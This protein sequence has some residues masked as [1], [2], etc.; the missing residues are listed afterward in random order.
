MARSMRL[1]ILFLSA[2]CVAVPWFGLNALSDADKTNDFE[3]MKTSVA[4][5]GL[6]IPLAAIGAVL[7][8][9]GLVLRKPNLGKGKKDDA[10]SCPGC[11]R[12]NALTTKVCPRCETRVA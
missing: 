10:I 11:G 7:T 1:S 9:L 3:A 6:V 8:I 2:A 5:S 4:F 12:K